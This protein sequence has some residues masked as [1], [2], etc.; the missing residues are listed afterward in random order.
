MLR[1]ALMALV[2]S[3][4][5]TLAAPAAAAP[6]DSAGSPSVS[7]HWD[8]PSD[9]ASVR[10]AA[11]GEPLQLVATL[12]GVDSIMGFQIEVRVHRGEA[13]KAWRF[14]ERDGCPAAQ[15]ETVAEGTTAVPA[16]WRSKLF[17]S[18]A[19]AMEAGQSRLMA[20]AAFHLEPVDAGAAYTL[21]RFKLQPPVSEEG[22]CA[23]WDSDARF[24]LVRV[25][26]LHARRQEREVHVLGGPVEL[27]V[28]T[29]P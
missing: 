1:I 20:L 23:G 14:E 22:G 5:L 11:P 6:A 25:S 26:Y 9:T 8:D 2:S 10:V 16:P 18:D 28:R 12:T 29:K 7:L 24:E 27:Q 21:C 4:L 15:L 3:S 13:S 17:L 19:R